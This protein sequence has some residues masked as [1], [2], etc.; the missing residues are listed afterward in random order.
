LTIPSRAVCGLIGPNGAGKSTFVD[1]VTGFLRRYEGSVQLGGVAIDA[2]TVHNRVRAGVRR[3]FQTERT[4][5]QLS[6]GDYVRLAARRKISSAEITELLSFLS[7]PASDLPIAEVDVGARR[8][9]ELAGAVAARPRIVLLDEPAAGLGQEAS[10]QL[11][12]R[13]SELPAHFGCAVLLIEHDMEVVSVS[14]SHITVLD[15][16]KE[17]ARGAPSEVLEMGAVVSAYLGDPGVA[18]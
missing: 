18:V 8:L 10:L 7:G 12:A 2:M 16:G 4:V 9:V 6:V 1:A 13:I 3:T 5:P 14:C 17:I 15:F 11:A